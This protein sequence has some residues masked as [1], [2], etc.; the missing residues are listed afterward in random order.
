MS[1][2]IH[3]GDKTIERRA[4]IIEMLENDGQVKIPKLSEIFKVSDV[5]IR[6]DLE[7]L[8]S[9]ELLVRSRGGALRINRVGIDY[10]LD[11]K[12]KKHI[13]EKQLIGAKAAELINENDTI[14]LDSG[15]TT[16]EVAKNLSKFQNLTVISNALNIAG[17]LVNFPNVR[18]I[19]PGGS[20]RKNSLSLI[21]AAAEEGFKHYF[22][23]KLFIG[24]DGIDSTNGISTPNVEECHINQ[25]MIK[26]AK[27]IIVVTDS[28]KFFKR[29]FAF[30]CSID[31]IHTII[32]DS[33]IPKEEH[34]KLVKLGKNVIIVTVEDE[35]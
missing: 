26:L 1:I 14:I 8:E 13:K 4:K 32:T 16:L 33:N 15:T 11:V 27:E 18:L 6:N 5:T 35:N 19:I 28:S 21:G 34:Q 23:D 3:N 30:I 2:G 29:S 10:Q 22:C 9:K 7:Q 17:H 31:K 24:V 20:L 25:V 12:S